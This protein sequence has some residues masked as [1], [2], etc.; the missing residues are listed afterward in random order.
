MKRSLSYAAKKLVANILGK[1]M[2]RCIVDYNSSRHYTSSKFAKHFL[3]ILN[4]IPGFISYFRAT[5]PYVEMDITS[6]CTLNCKECT[7][8]I[9]LYKQKGIVRD[10]D[11]TALLENIDLL[12]SKID[13]CFT[14]RVLGGEPFL[15]K[16]LSVILDR[17]TSE[18]KVKHVEVATNGT[19]LPDENTLRA[20]SHSKVSVGISNYGFLSCHKDELVK[21][22]TERG[23][24]VKL[25]DL[26]WYETNSLVY[27]NYTDKE[28]KS[29]LGRCVG[30]E[31]KCLYDGKLWLCPQALHGPVLGLVEANEAE[32][33]DLHE[34]TKKEFMRKLN[35]LYRY[36]DKITTCRYCTGVCPEFARQVPC[37]EQQEIVGIAE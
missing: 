9:P 5:I 28:V 24:T 6:K 2:I 19:I 27:R 37:A 1:R 23:I 30:S 33:I 32:F 17:L 22:C 4:V 7:H 16:D 10:I 8:F 21:I 18:P 20:L 26:V 12:M 25:A 34:C 13:K 14:F 35:K 11:V 31:F 36:S 29:I 3:T 15:H